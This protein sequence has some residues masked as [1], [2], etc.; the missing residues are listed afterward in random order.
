MKTQPPSLCHMSGGV[1]G[2]GTGWC[3]RWQSGRNPKQRSVCQRGRQGVSSAD[4]VIAINKD[5]DAPIF[6]VADYGIVGDVME[7]LPVMIEE[8]KKLRQ[9]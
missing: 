4:I 7:V 9:A 3:S 8:F 1:N 5:A 2:P 6:K